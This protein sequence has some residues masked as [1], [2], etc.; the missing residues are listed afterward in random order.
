M[1]RFGDIMDGIRESFPPS[2]GERLTGML[3]RVRALTVYVDDLNAYAETAGVD[4]DDIGDDYRTALRD[5]SV[6]TEEAQLVSDRMLVGLARD[7]PRTLLAAIEMCEFFETQIRGL[8]SRVT[9]QVTAI[10]AV[11]TEKAILEKQLNDSISENGKHIAKATEGLKGQLRASHEAKEN[12]QSSAD[13]YM[14]E[15]DA[16]REKHDKVFGE[17][18]TLRRKL[19]GFDPGWRGKLEGAAKPTPDDDLD[20]MDSIRPGGLGG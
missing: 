11:K 17:L 2:P 13:S 6:P 3:T 4:E 18:T 5:D 19:D 9:A 14:Q 12:A 8:N 16:S 15:R 20:W 10:R 1:A 7:V